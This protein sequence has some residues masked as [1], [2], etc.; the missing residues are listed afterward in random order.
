MAIKQLSVFVENKTGALAD[1]VS[2]LADSK[3][4]IR[5]LS[6]ADTQDFGILRMIVSDTEAAAAVLKESGAVLSVTEV[7]G[8]AISDEPGGLA[9]VLHLVTEN[10]I[11]MEYLY[12]FIAESGHEAYVV[13]RVD[14]NA[15]TEQI[16]TAGGVK[17]LS[18]A[19]IKGL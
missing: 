2:L 14:D 12:A 10:G 4:D 16:L 15:K 5:A 11:N 13:L 19:D 8:A 18:E 9:K 3:I 17:T 6:V 7:T 1:I